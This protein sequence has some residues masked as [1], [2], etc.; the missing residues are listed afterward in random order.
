VSQ[1]ERT[2][3]LAAV[4]IAG[5]PTRSELGFFR[6]LLMERWAVVHGRVVPIPRAFAG[7]PV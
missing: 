5:T 4:K 2:N 1:S 7:E 6:T 3:S